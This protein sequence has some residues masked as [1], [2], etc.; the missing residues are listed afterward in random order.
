SF[1]ADSIAAITGLD[2]Y[3]KPPIHALHFSLP[4][5]SRVSQHRALDCSPDDQTITSTDVAGAYGFNT[6]W[7]RGFHGENMTINLAEIDGS[8]K[9]DMQNYL[10]CIHFNGHLAFVDIDG[11]PSDVEGESTLDIQMAAGLAPASSIVVY[12]TDGSANGDTWTQVN[13]EL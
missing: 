3:S 2:N 11:S 8:Y 7:Q 10:G 6:L 4:Q 1:L 12:Q 13:D 5:G 9:D